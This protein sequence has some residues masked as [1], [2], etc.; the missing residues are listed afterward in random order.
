MSKVAGNCV[1]K[2]TPVLPEPLLAASADHTQRERDRLLKATGLLTAGA[3][4]VR[5]DNDDQ[6][7]MQFVSSVIHKTIRSDPD[8]G[9]LRWRNKH[10]QTAAIHILTVDVGRPPAKRSRPLPTRQRASA[11]T[12]RRGGQ[13]CVRS[14]AALAAIPS[15]TSRARK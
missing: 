15:S 13:R 14:R 9:K 7:L 8:L 5:V 2:I 11:A 12:H 6:V 10:V 3:K 4:G 1:L